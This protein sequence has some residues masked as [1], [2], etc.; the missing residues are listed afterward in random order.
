MVEEETRGQ[1]INMWQRNTFIISIL[2]IIDQI[3]KYLARTNTISFDTK[4][5]SF[6]FVKNTGAIFG[7]LQDSNHYLIWI[8]IIFLGGII[9]YYYNFPK[10]NRTPLIVIT[11]GII[12]NLTDRILLGY[13]TDFINFK[14]WP[15]FNVADSC[16][17]LGVIYL[18]YLEIKDQ[19]SSVS[20]KPSK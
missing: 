6:T 7:I 8:S 12:G 11:A 1:I 2:V 14:I 19:N 9:Y 10:K 16:I 18:L 3:S 17:V 5:L 4:I 15:V 13:V 20:S